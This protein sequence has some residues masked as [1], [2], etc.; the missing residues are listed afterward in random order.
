VLCDVYEN[1]LPFIRLG[2]YA[3]I[4]LNAYP[5]LVLKG[6]I[7]NIGPILDPNLRTGKVRLEVQNPGMLR[8]GMFVTAT[9]YGMKKEVHAT[10]PA[11]AVLHLHD[12]D[13]VY[14]PIEGGRFQ[15][16]EVVA[17][18]MLPGT[19][20]AGAPLVDAPGR[21]QDLL[22]Q[23]SGDRQEITSGIRPGQQVVA[24]ALDLQATVE[25]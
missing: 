2:E 4:H 8:L 5:D 20:R 18:K 14:V 17:G 7:G 22:L 24:N 16:L 11:S 3:D 19:G 6:R 1:D 25:Q 12:R 21:A 13:W 10:V 9:F 23:D 15:R